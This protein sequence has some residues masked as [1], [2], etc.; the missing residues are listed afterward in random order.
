MHSLNVCSPAF[1][2]D[3]K[4]PQ[5]KDQ[6]R[7]GD[8]VSGRGWV[9][10]GRGHRGA[11]RDEYR[12]LT[13][14]DGIWDK[15]WK[16]KRT[17]FVNGASDNLLCR[18]KHYTSVV[19][20]GKDRSEVLLAKKDMWSYKRLFQ[21]R[22]QPHWM[23]P[24]AILGVGTVEMSEGMLD[25]FLQGT[26]HLLRGKHTCTHMT[27]WEATCQGGGV[28]SAVLSCSSIFLSEVSGPWLFFICEFVKK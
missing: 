11:S 4:V 14:K 20:S 23:S 22:S 24:E 27:Q 12:M 2:R 6:C 3:T 13:W 21:Q 15:L 25:P 7:G 9:S 5:G 17:E 16:R 1:I 26:W 18:L 8:T 28:R 19:G 10:R